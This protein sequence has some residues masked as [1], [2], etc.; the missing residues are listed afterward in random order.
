MKRS[1]TLRVL[2]IGAIHS[3]LYLW[4]I[5]FVIVPRF[6][7]N[8]WLMAVIIAILISIAIVGSAFIGGKKR[9]G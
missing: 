3:M 7:H 6:G 4:L 9:D 5:P 1:V 8:G 2:V